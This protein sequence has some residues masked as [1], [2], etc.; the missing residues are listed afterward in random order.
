MKMEYSVQNFFSK[1][2]FYTNIANGL[3]EKILSDHAMLQAGRAEIHAIKE[4]EESIIIDAGGTNFRSCIVRKSG[5]GICISD[6]EKTYMPGTDRKVNKEEFYNAIAEN[7]SRLKDRSDRI[8]FCFSY[9]MEI[10][11]EGDGRILK[12]SKEINAQDAVG[13]FIGKELMAV[14]K[15]QGWKKV[16]KINVINDTAALLLSGIYA[17]QSNLGSSHVAFILGTGMNSAYVRN[18]RIVVTECGMFNGVQQSDF[19]RIADSGTAHPGQSVL[20]K[21]CSGAYLGEIVHA[22]IDTACDE[23][24]FSKEFINEAKNIAGLKASDLDPILRGEIKSGSESDQSILKTF[25]VAAVTRA[26]ELSAE[27]VYAAILDSDRNQGTGNA[28][29]S[30]NGST[31]WK[32]PFLKDIMESRLKTLLSDKFE[33]IQVS[34]DITVG[35]FASAFV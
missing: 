6:F 19:D 3:H 29:I 12:F 5:D 13:S 35:T 1:H 33:I 25:A 34:D 23:G 28:C 9:A 20:E 14:L 8:S 11:N 32:T 26:A 30:C 16:K 4:G 27:A 10:T 18:G 7:I 21:M 17:R 31:F 2:R 22:M 15:N 24:L